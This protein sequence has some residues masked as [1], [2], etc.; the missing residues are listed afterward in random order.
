VRVRLSPEGRRV[1]RYLIDGELAVT[2]RQA[3]GLLGV[4]LSMLDKWKA[5]G[6]IPAY[7]VAYSHDNRWLCLES[8]IRA[9]RDAEGE[10]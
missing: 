1:K 9:L 2:R 3:A 5:A 8:V 6:L 7:A 10:S 4:R